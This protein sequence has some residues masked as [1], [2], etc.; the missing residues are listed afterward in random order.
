MK[1]AVQVRPYR[2]VERGRAESVRGYVLRSGGRL[3]R[4]PSEPQAKP[5]GWIPEPDW[6]KG[7]YV[8]E[9]RGEAAWDQATKREALLREVAEVG[10]ADRDVNQ[11]S[12][13]SQGSVVVYDTKSG[14][15]ILIKTGEDDEE[16]DREVLASLV[17][18]AVGAG[19]PAV[20]QSGNELA[21][22]YV[23]GT[24]QAQ[25][26]NTHRGLEADRLIRRGWRI[27]VLDNLISNMDRQDF[28][29]MVTPD[30]VPVPIDAGFAVFDGTKSWTPFWVPDLVARD[31]LAAIKP[32][33][34][35][36]QPEFHARGRDQWFTNVMGVLSSFVPGDA[37]LEVRVLH[38][39]DAA[40]ADERVLP[41]SEGPAA[42]GR[43]IGA[44]ARVAVESNLDERLALQSAAANFWDH[45][46]AAAASGLRSA[47]RE[48]TARGNERLALRYREL[49]GAV[50]RTEHERQAA[51]V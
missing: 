35:A 38:D 48:A 15:K 42:L 33:L 51:A 36:L 50:L 41:I 24:T 22:E 8:W 14:G 17:S 12:S 3:G 5:A 40:L 31:Y 34:Q 16:R 37:P 21:E 23:P 11:P 44:Y 27:G 13:G 45:E 1:L 2:R 6:L 30:G 47:L 29:V 9:E 28:N 7:Q 32:R 43:Q 10:R 18:D 49:L 19:G 4:E 25:W 26:E 46:Y 39:V 20:V